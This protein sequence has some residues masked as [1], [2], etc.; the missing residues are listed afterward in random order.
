MWDAVLAGARWTS[1]IRQPR[2][3]CG[4]RRSTQ[5]SICY[6]TLLWARTFGFVSF[7]KF[8][9]HSKSLFHSKDFK[10]Y[11]KIEKQQLGDLSNK[12]KHYFSYIYINCIW[13]FFSVHWNQ[14][15]VHQTMTSSVTEFW[16]RGVSVGGDCWLPAM[17]THTDQRYI[18][19][20]WGQNWIISLQYY[21]ENQS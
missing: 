14:T 3:L 16:R 19:P 13:F 11:S 15:T 10:T 17:D 12:E 7:L 5:W 2:Q 4:P 21:I 1:G 6:W 8:V 18:L 20:L 9:C